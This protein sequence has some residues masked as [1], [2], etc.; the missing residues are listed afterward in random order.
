MTVEADSDH[1]HRSGLRW[2]IFPAHQPQSQSS[3]GSVVLGRVP[4]GRWKRPITDSCSGTGSASSAHCW[5]STRSGWWKDGWSGSATHRDHGVCCPTTGPG[6]FRCSGRCW[7]RMATTSPF[8]H[9]TRGPQEILAWHKFRF[10]DTA[11]ALIPNLPWPSLS[12]QTRISAD[13]DVIERTLVGAE[14]ELY[15]DH[16]QALAAHHLVLDPWPGLLLRHVP[17]VSVQG[18]AGVRHRAARQ[19]S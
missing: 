8:C 3:V 2:R 4:M 12:G 14:L 1:R 5:L 10:L 15:D 11:A 9:R 13:P 6:A 18:C 7:L 16:A 19:Q 17:G